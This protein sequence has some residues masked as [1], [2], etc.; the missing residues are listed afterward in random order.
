MIRAVYREGSIQPVDPL[1]SGWREGQELEVREPQ[2][3]EGT[4]RPPT[5]KGIETCA[6]NGTE[7][8]EGLNEEDF[9]RFLAALEENERESKALGRRELERSP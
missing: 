9:A 6:A 2:I 7:A 5:P 8:A 1:P 3:A 4:R